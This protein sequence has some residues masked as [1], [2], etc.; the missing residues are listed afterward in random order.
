MSTETVFKQLADPPIGYNTDYLKPQYCPYDGNC[1]ILTEDRAPQELSLYDLDKQMIIKKYRAPYY[2]DI[3]P[4]EFQC[5][6]QQN[7]KIYCITRDAIIISVDLNN[8]KWEITEPKCSQIRITNC[9][10]I[11]SINQLYLT[12]LLSCY[13]YDVSQNKLIKMRKNR[14]FKSNA[15]FVCHKSAQKCIMYQGD[16]VL[17]SDINIKRRS[18]TD[19]KSVHNGYG[20][21]MHVLPDSGYSSSFH[22]AFDQILFHVMIINRRWSWMH[23]NNDNNLEIWCLDLNRKKHRTKWYKVY[24]RKK[25]PY[26]FDVHVIKDENNYLHLIN[27]YGGHH[28]HIKVALVDLIPSEIIKSNE[29]KKE[30]LIV[31]YIKEHQRRN[32]EIFLPMYLKRIAMR[33]FPLFV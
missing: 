1:I 25:I 27:F 10:F 29:R 2:M 22:L 33:Y 30:H 24:I 6:D 4:F 12:S 3:P 13:K 19:W 5:V 17:L 8:N 31:G 15:S 21:P 28:F 7:D 18:M 16:G 11:P 26:S 20:D 9:Y 14:Q 32:P 23:N